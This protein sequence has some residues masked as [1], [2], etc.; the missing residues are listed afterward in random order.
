M[1]KKV[2]T[3][4]PDY[5]D[6][7]KSGDFLFIESSHVIRL[8]GDVLYEILEVL[9]RFKSGVIVHIHDIF[10]PRDYC[11]GTVFTS[12][13]FWNEKYLLEAFLSYN[14]NYKLLCAVK[15]LH[16]TYPEVLK[17]SCPNLEHYDSDPCSFWIQ[18]LDL[19]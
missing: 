4:S 9:G 10:T 14:T 2:E 5:F 11:F 18:K 3:L 13:L 19:K 1:R 16:K 8:L 17:K 15:H 7:L 6:C 12:Q